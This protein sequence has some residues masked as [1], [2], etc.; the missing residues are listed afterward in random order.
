MRIVAGIIGFSEIL[1][2]SDL[3]YEQRESLGVL[4]ELEKLR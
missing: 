3:I 1:T 4:R 2:D